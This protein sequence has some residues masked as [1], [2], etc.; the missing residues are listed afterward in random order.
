MGYWQTMQ[1]LMQTDEGFVIDNKG[2]R[3][4][5]SNSIER[6]TQCIRQLVTNLYVEYMCFEALASTA[7]EVHRLIQTWP[8]DRLQRPNDSV[9]E[10]LLRYQIV[11]EQAIRLF[12]NDFLTAVKTAPAYRGYCVRE[13]RWT[14]EQFIYIKEAARNN[15]F[16]N[17]IRELDD[18]EFITLLDGPYEVVNAIDRHFR[19]NPAIVKTISQTAMRTFSHL[20]YVSLLL[21]NL[22][23][24]EP[25]A[26]MLHTYRD[27]KQ[28]RVARWWENGTGKQIK[29]VEESIKKLEMRKGWTPSPAKY[30]YPF[31]TSWREDINRRIQ[32][33]KYLDLDWADVEQALSKV[34]YDGGSH[35]LESNFTS[36]VVIIRTPP[37]PEPSPELTDNEL[38]SVPHATVEEASKNYAAEVR[39][40]FKAAAAAQSKKRK[41]DITSSGPNN[42]RGDSSTIEN[43]LATAPMNPP[44]A[45]QPKLMVRTET[46][47]ILQFNMYFLDSTQAKTL[48]WEDL[49]KAMLELGFIGTCTGGSHFHFKPVPGTSTSEVS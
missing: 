27:M 35:E 10:A 34:F 4:L 11:L 2:H 42:P 8:L 30:E 9:M 41:Q 18:N 36:P 5:S 46:M 19:R 37:L 43:V 1:D 17:M 15:A 3:N 23:M 22:H 40:A 28:D 47:T 16:L 39:A 38:C 7:R 21:N 13:A 49:R 33:E 20:A 48:P 14:R 12:K 29:R 24:F 31:E 25:W 6:R 44:P 32:A 45:P 26:I